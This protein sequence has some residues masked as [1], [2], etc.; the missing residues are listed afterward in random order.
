MIVLSINVTYLEANDIRIRL[1]D[2]LKDALTSILEPQNT[3]FRILKHE[4]L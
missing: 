3:M 4:I 1:L 2:F